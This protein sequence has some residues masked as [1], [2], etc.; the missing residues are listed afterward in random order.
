MVCSSQQYDNTTPRDVRATRQPHIPVRCVVELVTADAGGGV[1]GTMTTR[2]GPG[3]GRPGPGLNAI[4]GERRRL[5]NVAYRLLGSLAEA[6][7]AVQ[8]SYA[9]WYA[10]ETPAAG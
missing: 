9:R 3:D 7:D 5:I 1:V 2:S 4:M 8:E 6:E 10:M